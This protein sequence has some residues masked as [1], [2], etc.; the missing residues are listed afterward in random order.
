MTLAGEEHDGFA[1]GHQYQCNE[2]ERAVRDVQR[3][4]DE[5]NPCGRPRRHLER[6]HPCQVV[7]GHVLKDE[8]GTHACAN[9]VRYVF[10]KSFKIDATERQTVLIPVQLR[11]R[12]VSRQVSHQCLQVNIN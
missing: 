3:E 8:H 5:T 11:V 10:G 9:I 12:L 6:N 2:H 4:A 1:H 7:V